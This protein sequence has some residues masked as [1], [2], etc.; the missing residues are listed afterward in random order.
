VKLKLKLNLSRSRLAVP[1]TLRPALHCHH[2]HP[3][4]IGALLP[5]CHFGRSRVSRQSA[6]SVGY[7]K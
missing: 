5:W 7:G 4:T 3:A 6:E 2:E 1:A